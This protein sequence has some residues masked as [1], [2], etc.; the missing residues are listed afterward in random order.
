MFSKLYKKKVATIGLYFRIGYQQLTFKKLFVMLRYFFLVYICKK[1]IPWVVEFSITYNCQC[2]CLHCSVADYLNKNKASDELTTKQCKDLLVQIK[3][4]GIPKVDFFGGEPLIRKDIIELSKFGSSIGLFISITTNALTITRDLIKNLKKAKISYISI[5][6]D[7]ADE[8]KHDRLRGIRGLY[9][10]VLNAVKFCY[11]EKLPCLIS[12]YVT[13]NDIL[14][15]GS[16]NDNSNLSRIISLSKE[17]KASGIRIL[18]PIISGKWLENKKMALLLTEQ[19][20]ILDSLDYSFA[21][22]EGAFSVIKGKKICQS[23][24]G[25]MFNISPYGDVQ[26]CVTYPKSFG[27]IKEKRLKD[28]LHDMYTHKIY[29]ENVGRS[30]CS[31][32]DLVEK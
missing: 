25:K 3:N 22:I 31:S 23:L 11:E 1:N 19:K 15:F 28:V 26:L 4:I 21:F 14:G 18:F 13:R 8:K 30:C 20:Q 17:I 9:D 32:N 7:S 29:T 10:I 27:N 2:K 12:T 6:L 24:I 16:R 5:S